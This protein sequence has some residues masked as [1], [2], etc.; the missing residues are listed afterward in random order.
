MVPFRI[1]EPTYQL[2]LLSKSGRNYFLYYKIERG[3]NMG[4]E[5]QSCEI[6]P[7]VA[8]ISQLMEDSVRNTKQHKVF[9]DKFENLNIST[10]VTE[11]RY[12]VI[13]QSINSLTAKVE[14]ISNVPASRWNA[15]VMVVLGALLGGIITA[16]MTKILY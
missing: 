5:K 13:I 6:C 11:E 14:G 3:I 12:S 4:N 8:Q 2:E 1:K 16:F 9:Y 15:S 7:Y 10:A